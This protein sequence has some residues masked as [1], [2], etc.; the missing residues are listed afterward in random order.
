MKKVIVFGT[1]DLIH[2][3]HL[4]MFKQAKE[5]GDFLVIVI[6]RDKIT[7]QIKGKLPINNEEVRLANIKKLNVADRVRLGCLDDHYRVIKEEKP[8]I[9]ALGYDQKAFV[10]SLS[11]I[12]EDHCQIVRLSPYKPEIYKSS[13][14]K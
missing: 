3:G 9:V 13:K 14:L 5:Y 6:S 10:D 7:C 8:D 11:E 1:F 12:I 4:H 2:P